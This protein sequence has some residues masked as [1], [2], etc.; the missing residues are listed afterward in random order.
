MSSIITVLCLVWLFYQAKELVHDI[1][2]RGKF[3]VLSVLAAKLLSCGK[4]QS[5]WLILTLSQ[6]LAL[7]CLAGFAAELY[8]TFKYRLAQ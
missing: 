5:F 8:S 6:S 1:R 3:S 4:C 2:S 7:A